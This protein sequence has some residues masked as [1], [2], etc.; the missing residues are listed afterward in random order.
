VVPAPGAGGPPGRGPWTAIWSSWPR[1]PG[2]RRRA[3]GSARW[4]RG[5]GWTGSRCPATT[6]GSGRCGPGSRGPRNRPRE[7]RLSPWTCCAAPSIA[8]G[9][10]RRRC[11]L[12]RRARPTLDACP[13]CGGSGGVP[14]M[15]HVRPAPKLARPRMNALAKGSGKASRPHQARE[16]YFRRCSRIP[17]GGNSGGNCRPTLVGPTKNRLRRDAE[18]GFVRFCARIIGLV[19]RCTCPKPCF[20]GPSDP[21]NF[22]GNL[23]GGDPWSSHKLRG[24]HAPGCAALPRRARES[25]R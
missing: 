20:T 11:S 7:G 8:G 5:T 4:P 23:S 12:I 1:W 6:P 22:P 17:S 24:A 2:S 19:D 21:A 14:V 25:S 16:D 3:G 15:R 13:T 10:M 9:P 18:G